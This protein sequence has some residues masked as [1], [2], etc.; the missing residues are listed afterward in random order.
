M[1]VFWELVP[2]FKESIAILRRTVK[3][4]LQTQGPYSCPVAKHVPA[5]PSALQQPPNLIR[6]LPPRRHK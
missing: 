1:L 5:A 4:S 2:L 3:A 6:E